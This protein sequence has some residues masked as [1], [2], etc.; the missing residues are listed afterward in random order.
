MNSNITSYKVRYLFLLTIVAVLLVGL[1]SRLA[2]LHVFE[3]T[4]LQ[5]QGNARS[6][7]TVELQ[8]PRGVIQDRNGE[9]L[10]VST[11][12]KAVWIDPKNF[13]A[14]REQLDQLLSVLNLP[15]DDFVKKLNFNR[16]K[17]FLYIKRNVIPSV[18][19]QVV[20]LEIPGLNVKPEY[21]RY[22]P[23]GEVNSHVL[24]ITNIDDQG[25]EGI[26]LAYNNW[27]SGNVEKRRVIKDL[28]G[29]EI[30]FLDSGNTEKAGRNLVLSIDQRLQY[31]AY[32]ELK[33]AVE[34]HKAVSGS[35][36]VLS[37]DT[38][39]VLAMVNQ[40]T[41]NPNIRNKD[42]DINKCRNVA[43]TDYFEPA[44]AVK[45]FSMASV[46]EHTNI[47]AK[48]MVN[49][50]PGF[51]VLKGGTVRDL[52]NNG[53][54]SVSTMLRKSSNVGIS[55]LVLSLPDEALWD[56]YDRLG[57]GFTT[58]SNFPGENSGVLVAPNISKPF[59]KATMA[60]GYGLGVTSL[61]L[62]RAYATLGSG[63]I[64]KPV[65]FLK[66]EGEVPGVRVFST[67]VSR[68]IVD[69]L[70]A[71]ID[72]GPSKAKVPGYHVAGKTGTARKLGKDG[73]YKDSKHLA[74]FGGL[75]PAINSKFAIV[76]TIN[77]PSAGKF[78]SNQVAAPVFSNIAAGALR[79][80]D[81]A[82]DLMEIQGVHVAQHGSNHL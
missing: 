53:L 33:K 73:Y 82:P 30:G 28:L 68:D 72:N 45:A 38:G 74:V 7:R 26:E 61:Q 16:N 43:V 66:V 46:L 9:P 57:F 23:T 13:A 67:K 39:E 59:V 64:R 75:A 55:K 47:T 32:R 78:Y 79:L 41:F 77:E 4:F 5:K 24:G 6:T 11:M 35:A 69:M 29:R 71:V 50:A 44:S 37:V 51:M 25:Q 65:S 34:E 22:Y 60:F 14:T 70:N 27:L 49:T 2:Y 20:A 15:K 8:G 12:V 56:T 48:T 3:Q 76:V 40:P 17:S 62:A 10:A 42:I 1:I 54:I 80:F 36:V 19:E 58:G 18:E 52:Q 81:I 21:K 31:L 63:G